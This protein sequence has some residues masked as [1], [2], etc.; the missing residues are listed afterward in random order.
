MSNCCDED[1]VVGV[2]N[3]SNPLGLR[4]EGHSSGDTIVF[5]FTKYR[6][7]GVSEIRV[8]IDNVFLW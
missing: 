5:W 1:C 7:G 4:Q 3:L 8:S 2:M 6:K